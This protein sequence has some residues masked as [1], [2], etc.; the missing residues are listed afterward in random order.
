MVILLKFRALKMSAWILKVNFCIVAWKSSNQ[1][2]RPN[3]DNANRP[4][5]KTFLHKKSAAQ[6]SKKNYSECIA[7]QIILQR[8]HFAKPLLRGDDKEQ[9]CEFFASSGKYS[10]LNFYVLFSK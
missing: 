9:N 3:L 4:L 5:A 7:L 6:S 1:T 8:R 10:E 2:D